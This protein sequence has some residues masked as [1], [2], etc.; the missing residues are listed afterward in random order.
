MKTLTK[1]ASVI[2]V[3]SFLLCVKSAHAVVGIPVVDGA[4]ELHHKW[5]VAV[6]YAAKVQHY[7]NV[8][9]NWDIH[10]KSLVADKID[11]LLGTDKMKGL[12]ESEVAA[13]FSERNAECTRSASL[14]SV[15]LCRR[16]VK[17]NKEIYKTR[18]ESYKKIEELEKK[19]NEKMA[20]VNGLTGAGD[21]G[22]RD[23]LMSEIQI[24]IADKTNTYADLN[25]KIK[26][27]EGD[28]SLISEERQR[29]INNQ[30]RGNATAALATE[31]TVAYGVQNKANDWQKRAERLRINKNNPEST[32]ALMINSRFQN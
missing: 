14:K 12:T 8:I 10:L 3:T 24:L 15:E 32:N 13:H 16:V 9:S 25:G 7:A 6:E 27:L 29:I 4:A 1:K 21:K 22:K 20:R 23:S 19:I 18:T 17:L 5:Q 28:I 2:A 30:V 26:T 11:Q 31:G